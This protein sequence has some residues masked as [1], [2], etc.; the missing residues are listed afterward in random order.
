MCIRDRLKTAHFHHELTNIP[1][2]QDDEK[3]EQ[4]QKDKK[5]IKNKNKKSVGDFY[6]WKK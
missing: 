5:S 3:M 6:I 2:I 4:K 1:N